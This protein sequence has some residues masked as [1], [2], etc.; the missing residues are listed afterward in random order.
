MPVTIDIRRFGNDLF[1]FSLLFMALT[2]PFANAA[3]NVVYGCL[4]I[5][6]V[7]GLSW[8]YFKMEKWMRLHLLLF[9]SLYF[10]CLIGMLYTSDITKGMARLEAKLAILIFPVLLGFGPRIDRQ[11]YITV[12]KGFV[13]SCLMAILV[14]MG[15]A[16]HRL[17]FFRDSFG[18]SKNW[19][20]YTFNGIMDSSDLNWDYLSYSEFCSFIDLPPAYFSLYLGFSALIVFTFLLF[21]WKIW[22]NYN[23]SWAIALIFF[24]ILFIIQLSTRGVIIAFILSFYFYIFYSFSSRKM[25]KTLIITFVT[26]NAF[27]IS[28]VY[29]SP[30]TKYRITEALTTIDLSIGGE[31]EI[32]NAVNMRVVNWRCSIEIIIDNLLFGVGTGDD[33]IYLNQCYL[34]YNMGINNPY[35]NSHNDFLQTGVNFGLIGMFLFGLVLVIPLIVAVRKKHHLYVIFLILFTLSCLTVSLLNGQKGT[36]FYG[37]FNS[38]LVFQYYRTT[39]EKNFG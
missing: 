17:F 10:L 6:W 37:F 29:L 36:I 7:L 1:Y 13:F 30:V 5:S 14:S 18:R 4:M 8:D 19:N 25:Y 9:V 21:N 28:A 12:L 33:K 11:R 3:N 27:L 26:L 2:L 31:T 38:L 34:N 35:L 32:T 24:F 15:Y 16:F 22:T 20:Q 39:K 23:K